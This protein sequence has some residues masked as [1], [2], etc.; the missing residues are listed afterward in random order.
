MLQ[1]NQLSHTYY[2]VPSTFLG[3]HCN[4][5]LSSYHIHCIYWNISTVCVALFIEYVELY[6]NL[7]YSI[8]SNFSCHDSPFPPLSTLYTVYQK[9][10]NNL[11]CL[12][13]KTNVTCI[14]WDVTWKQVI[15]VDWYSSKTFVTASKTD[16]HIKCF[17][18][19]DAICKSHETRRR[20][21]IPDSTCLTESQLA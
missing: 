19:R 11:T 3:C 1:P 13:V 21:S 7:Y 18:Q 12:Y 14:F 17:T 20:G 9:C 6:S 4:T 10:S 15:R 16:A 5:S 2:S 8:Q